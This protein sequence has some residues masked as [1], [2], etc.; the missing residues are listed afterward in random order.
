MY[1]LNEFTPEYITELPKNCVFV[2]GTNTQGIHGAGSAK[3]A[4]FNFD[5]ILGQAEGLQGR[6]YGIITKELRGYLP[7]VTLQHIREGVERFYAFAATR[8]DLKFYV[9][10]IGTLRGG[11]TV[12]EIGD[13]FRALAPKISPNIVLPKEFV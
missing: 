7:P 2:A 5:A 12:N 10:K 4:R 6:A 9:T 8:P 1:T 11:F 3:T 13:I